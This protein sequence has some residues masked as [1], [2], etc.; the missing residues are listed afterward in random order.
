YRR[1]APLAP[2]CPTAWSDQGAASGD[3]G[4][5]RGST[6]GFHRTVVAAGVRHVPRSG[7]I[8]RGQTLCGVGTII[9]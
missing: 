5:Q 8:G 1:R 7:C 6:T 9:C 2:R 3:R 4:R